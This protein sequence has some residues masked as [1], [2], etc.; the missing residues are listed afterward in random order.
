MLN[1]KY[2]FSGI[3]EEAGHVVALAKDNDK[4]HITMKCSFNH[5]FKIDQNLSHNYH[6]PAM[7]QWIIPQHDL[8]INIVQKSKT[9]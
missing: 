4:L 7:N 2:L 9:S 1:Y 8:I 5:E 6:N 3:V